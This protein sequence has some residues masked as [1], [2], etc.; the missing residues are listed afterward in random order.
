M[1]TKKLPAITIVSITLILVALTFLSLTTSCKKATALNSD[2]YKYSI[3]QVYADGLETASLESVGMSVGPIEEMMD[4]LKSENQ[5][6]TGGHTIHN[7]LIVKDN[8]LVFEEYFK[9]YKFVIT[10][11]DFNGEVMDYTR[12][13]DHFMA[14]VSKSVTS[15]VFGIAVKE[16]YFNDLNKKIIDYLPQYSDILTGQ[17]ANITLH[18]LL[19][20]TCGLAFDETTYNYGD[21]RNE[22]RQAI[23]ATDPLLFIL[24]K[25]LEAAPGTRFH[26]SSG[27]G[28][29]LAA[30]LEKV[31]GTK[32]LDYANAMLFDPLRSEGGAWT[33]T[34]SGLIFASGGLYLKARELTKIGLLFLNAGQWEGKQIIT[35]VWI[36]L[37][38]QTQV[39]STGNYLPNSLYSYQWWTTTFTVKGVPRKCF[40]AAG[41]GGQYMFIIP[42]LNLI[43]EM[44]AGNYLGTDR[45][46]QLDLVTGYILR[47][48]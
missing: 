38:Q 33:A 48:I 47:T 9:G 27:S 21:T 4:Y 29:V 45:V 30:I 1:K 12:T 31:T 25:P 42:D 37:T 7:I 43:I 28:L 44:N 2:G 17:K 46:S 18:H 41:W 32:F 5:K 10:A 36:A 3:P 35:P 20:M 24:S 22:L 34:S 14:S 11:P 6:T 16:G 19:T 23:S 26:Y 8:K 40:Y 13:T 39:T 15:V